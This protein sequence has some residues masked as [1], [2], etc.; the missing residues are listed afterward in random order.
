MNSQS[1]WLNERMWNR[2]NRRN[3]AFVARFMVILIGLVIL[4][5]V[6]F[7]FIMAYEG[8]DFSWISGLYWTLTTMSTLGFGDITFT[9]DVGMIFSVVVLLS[10]TTF[11]LALF[12]FLFIQ[13]FYTPWLEAQQAARSPRQI[14]TGT[15]GHIVLTHYGEIA[16]AFIQ[17][18]KRHRYPYVLLAPTI[19][20]TLKLRDQGFNAIFGECD[21]ADTYRNVHVEK[22]ALV[23]ATGKDEVNANI[24]FTVRELNNTLPI[25]ATANDPASVDILE[26]AGCSHVIQLAELMGQALARRTLAGDAIAHIIGRFDEMLIAEA[27]THNTPL[28][29]KTL[30]ESGLRE[31]VSVSVV[32]IWE[33]G[34]YIQPRPETLISKGSVLVLAGSKEQLHT[35]NDLFCIYN[36]ATNPIVIIGGGRVGRATGQA[37]QK[38]GID[39]RIV[40]KIPERIRNPE[41]Y[42][43]GNAADIEVLTRAGI[44]KAPTVVI[45]SHDDDMN[46]YLTIYCRKLRPDIQIITRAIQERNVST[47]HRAGADIVMS[48][49]SMGASILF[50]LLKRTDI[51]LLAEGLDFFRVKIPASLAGSTLVESNIRQKTGCTV[52]AVRADGKTIITPDPQSALP[53]NGE[54]ILVGNE[55]AEEKFIKMFGAR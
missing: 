46:V 51:V 7:H 18:L 32:G 6:L 41:N 22:A 33:R 47:L 9:T 13:F 40:E 38:R 34:R 31:M 2:V 12:P 27:T 8:R 50:N 37:L 5:S 49:A 21:D 28:V 55:E 54:L 26:L 4:Y 35:Y 10:G 20:D 43:L 39:Y 16:S 42:V 23:V 44:Q 24:A 48:Y 29:G 25:A 3:L 45:T 1:R 53:S 19:D 17:K 52:I 30:K 36:T 14:P 15:H 11:M